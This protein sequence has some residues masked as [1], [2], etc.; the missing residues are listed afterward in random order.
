MIR[1]KGL[2]TCLL[3]FFILSIGCIGCVPMAEIALSP[4]APDDLPGCYAIFP[5]GHWESVHRI[6]AIIKGGASS[7]LIGVTKGEPS[8]RRL[9]SLLLTPEG[10]ILFDG[11]LRGGEIT[12]RKAVAPFDSP[13]FAKG[14]ME[15]VALLFL[16]PQVRPT[17]WGKA[18]DGTRICRWESPD[19][20]RTEVWESMDRGWRIQHRDDQ[21]E[22]TR[23]VSLKGPFVQGL[24]SH[25]ELRASKPASYRL[26][27]TLLQAS[28]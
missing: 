18:A 16:P 7:S 28:P 22:V 10:F 1:R 14:L 3:G 13:A 6:E 21:G 25:M 2:D 23:E 27:M 15:D 5:A 24:A 11:E 20:C 19:G 17:I 8:E 26:R 4:G 9:Q 12:V